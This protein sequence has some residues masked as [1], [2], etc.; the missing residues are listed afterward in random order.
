MAMHLIGGTPLPSEELEQA[1]LI[2]WA[3]MA[4]IPHDFPGLGGQRIGDFLFA[5]PNGTF[6]AGDR[7][8][9]AM[10]MARLKR[11]G[12]RPG[13]HDLFLMVPAHGSH[14]LFIEMKRAKRSATSGAQKTFATK[15]AL[16]G[17]ACALAKGADQAMEA[18]TGYLKGPDLPDDLQFPIDA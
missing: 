6:L 7:K 14:G 4:M 5:V 13:V 8:R 16:A 18:I 1:A 17:Y 9:R 3:D 10:Q 11:A 12:L 15:A 2:Q